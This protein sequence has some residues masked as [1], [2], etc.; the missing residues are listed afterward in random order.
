MKAIIFDIDGVILKTD[1]ILKEIEELE[2]KDNDR[3]DYFHAKCNNEQVTS[4][5]GICDLISKYLTL[6]SIS[7]YYVIFSTA[8]EEVV[9]WQTLNKLN[10]VIDGIIKLGNSRLYMRKQ[11]DTRPAYIIKQEHLK[12]IQEKYEV[13][14][15]FDDN[16]EN[17][18]MYK[19]NG[20]TAL[21]II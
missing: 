15:V 18:K 2:L 16:L 3:W 10:S 7:D 13:M 14:L 6:E 5:K 12:E 8:R 9:R 4:N 11:G 19:E 1:F 20:I 21:N 17:C